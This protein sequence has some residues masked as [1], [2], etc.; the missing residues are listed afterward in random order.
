MVSAE[1]LL[2]VVTN[3]LANSSTT[4]Y[5]QDGVTFANAMENQLTSQGNPIG[6]IGTGSAAVGQYTDFSAG[7]VMS[8]GNALDVAINSAQGALAVQTAPNTISYTR[9]GSL[10]VD[11]NRQ[12]VTKQGY[13]VLGKDL[14][15]IKLGPGE[16]QIQEDGTVTA[17]GVIGGTIGVFDGQFQKQGSNLFSADGQVN[18]ITPVLAPRSLEASNVNPVMAMLQMITLNRTYELSQNAVQQH[19]NLTSRLISSLQN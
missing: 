7:S 4:G 17:N 8:T 13:P 2:D 19:D 10:A 14:Q 15:P 6:S 1:Q 18:S 5:K 3:N 11:Q 12:L 16:I 9:D